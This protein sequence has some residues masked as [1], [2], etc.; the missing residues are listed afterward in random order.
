MASE[1][2]ESRRNVLTPEQDWEKTSLYVATRDLLITVT[3]SRTGL[4]P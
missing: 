2:N 3:T 4:I 1:I